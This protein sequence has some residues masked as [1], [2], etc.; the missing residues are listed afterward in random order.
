[1]PMIEPDSADPAALACALSFVAEQA[2]IHIGSVMVAALLKSTRRAALGE[3][4]VLQHFTVAQEGRV[5][6]SPAA[7]T[8]RESVGA[9]AAWTSAFLNASKSVLESAH[10]V[11]VRQVTYMLEEELD[12]C[13]F[14]EWLDRL[15]T[16]P[17]TEEEPP[18]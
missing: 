1:V 8:N 3:H 5:D 12:R 14:Y 10:T 6:G 13:H 4:P 17:T 18:R 7:L 2:R 15:G 16:L 9:M 11:P